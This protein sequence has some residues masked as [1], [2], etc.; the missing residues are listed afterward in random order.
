MRTAKIVVAGMFVVVMIWIA[1]AG[2]RWA[3]RQSQ[4]CEDSYQKAID[5]L[6]EQ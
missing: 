3:Q 6:K 1:I 5:T 4:I 2:G